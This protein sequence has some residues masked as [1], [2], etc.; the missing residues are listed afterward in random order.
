MAI[1]SSIRRIVTGW[2][3]NIAPGHDDIELG[4]PEP[5]VDDCEEP[6]ILEVEGCDAECVPYLA[7]RVVFLAVHSGETM[8]RMRFLA[9]PLQMLFR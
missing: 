5:A 9:L 1:Q 3:I 8:S 6:S 4:E 2:D 7:S